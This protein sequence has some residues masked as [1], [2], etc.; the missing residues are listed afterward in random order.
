M[1]QLMR[2]TTLSCVALLVAC[3]GP[4]G[5]TVP[6]ATSVSPTVAARGDTITVTGTRFG[7]TPGS[8]TVGG[9]SAAI[10]DWTDTAIEATVPDTAFNAWQD[11]E[12]TTAGG[13]STVP[14]LFV[15]VEFDGTGPELQAFL[16]GLATGTAV[17]LQAET[18]DLTAYPDQILI[19]NKDLY[20]RGADETTLTLT[21]TGPTIIVADFGKATTVAD[22]TMIGDDI[23][24]LNGDLSDTVLPANVGVAHITLDRVTFS[25]AASGVFGNALGVA[26]KVDVT[27]RDSVVDVPNGYIGL[28]TSGSIV[29]ENSELEADAIEMGTYLGSLEILNS[30][31]VTYNAIFAAEAGLYIT[32]STLL[33]T[34]GDLELV[35]AANAIIGGSGLPTGGPVEV[36]GS[37]IE[38][39]DGDLANG[40]DVG[41]LEIRTQFAPI[42]L[43]E[44]TLVR[45]H[46][47][48]VLQALSS[49]AGESDIELVGNLDVRVGV[50]E[51]E[52]AVNYRASSLVVITNSSNIRDRIEL[53]GNTIVSSDAVIIQATGLS[54]DVFIGDNTIALGDDLPGSL[55]AVVTNEGRI[56]VTD[57]SVSNI[58]LAQ[59]IAS[60]LGGDELVL[61]GNQFSHS[62]AAAGTVL[63]QA[64]A[65]SCDVTDNRVDFD[66]PTDANGNV[67]V[68]FC[69][70]D[71]PGQHV[72]LTGNEFTATGSAGSVVAGMFSGAGTIT[73]AAND[74]TSDGSIQFNIDEATAALSEND[75]ALVGAPLVV[76]GVG[77]ADLTLAGN[78]VSHS[79]PTGPGLVL[80][81]VGNASVTDNTLTVTGTPGPAAIALAAIASSN[82]IALTAT[83]NTFTGYN[84]ALYFG[85]VNG[86]AL[87]IDATLNDNVFDFVIDAAPKVAELENVK[88]EIDARNNVWGT[89]TDLA[90]V[91]SYVTLSGDT[92]VQGGS[93]LLGPI[94]QP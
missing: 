48:L 27:V 19:D 32:D 59:F 2:L 53:L 82:P 64:V 34:D 37:S 11:V 67:V 22:L 56:E 40:I 86:G 38:V 10:T 50:F 7:T 62:A 89:N 60:D 87:G 4:T 81:D 15:G 47:D 39:L 76:Y 33:I 20:G 73:V 28:V 83:G 17:L 84:Q 31:V 71:D 70:M 49:F 91:E 18:Y 9:V 3:G 72:D 55:V 42:R 85:D 1:R 29:F 41:S 57:N 26:A 12:V 51:A 8:L 88:D 5:P 21:P 52:D 36:S 46:D 16:D 79:D 90:T 23:R 74:F 30:D 93:I 75:F 44:N 68:L 54:G 58:V 80:Q 92:A 45:V 25:E 94:T 6:Q 65:G 61:S 77:A 78:T 13:T 14:D 66:D 35:G 63:V 43:I 69:T 24:F